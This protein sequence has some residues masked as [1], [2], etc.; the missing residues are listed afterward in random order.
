[1]VTLSTLMY[2]I[3][4][5]RI[6]SVTMWYHFAFMAVSVAM[7]GMTVGAILVYLAPTFFAPE[8]VRYHLALSSTLFSVF[9]VVSFLIHLRIPFAPDLPTLRIARL[10]PFALTY[11]VV[12]IPFILSGVCVCLALTKF[13]RDVSRMYA[14]DLAGAAIGC[15]A[16]IYTLNI[17]DGPTAV[18]AVAALAGIG[19]VLFALDSG[20]AWLTAIAA[21]SAVVLSSLAVAHTVLVRNGS[22]LLRITY[23][24]GQRESPPL[25]EK[26]N[27]F[28]RITVVGSRDV[29]GPPSGWGLSPAWR[30]RT[31]VRQLCLWIDSAAATPLTAFDGNLDGVRHLKYDVTNV[32]HYVRPNSKVLVI[33]VG[34]GRDILSA[35]AFHQRSVLGVEMNEN[36]IDAVNH[37]FGAFTGHL[38][39]NPRITFVAD[40]ARSYVTR[41][42]E[43]FDIIQVSLID[44]WAATA[45][46]AFVLAEQSLY[47]VEAWDAFLEKLTPAGVLTFSRWYFSS[48]PGEMYR[49]ASLA[50]VSLEKLGVKDPRN[51]IVI[52]CKMPGGPQPDAPMG[53][54][55]IL[56]SKRPFS[57]RDLDTID[58]VSRKMGFEVVLSPR[59]TH[60]R[61]F[62]AIATVKDLDA[63]IAGLPF[64]ITAPTDDS[65]F[66]FHML[67]LRDMFGQ[68]PWREGYAAINV[69]AVAV[70]GWL[71]IVVIVLTFLCIFVPLLLTAKRAALGGALPLMAFFGSIGLGFMLIEISQLQRLVVFL[72]HP[73]YALS[74]VLFSLLVSSSL[75]SYLTGGAEDR[76]LGRSGRAR[77]LLLLVVLVAFGLLTPRLIPVFRGSITGV[78]I[79]VATGILLPLGLFMGMPFP[80]GMKLAAERSRSLTPW[81]WGINGATSVCASVLAVAIALSAGISAAFW[82]GLLCYA[83]ALLAFVGASRGRA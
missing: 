42:E 73:S 78:R 17:T 36:I 76:D 67:R 60:A 22:P 29:A 64:N 7:F 26:W 10:Y 38:D 8:R 70:L 39:R 82:T 49:L 24:K 9:I 52:V 6:F 20:R 68:R 63:Y 79:L 14:A 44:T 80:L 72:G 1:M 74:V 35:L 56:A 4:L 83:A 19:A 59:R 27:A 55:T 47:T 50:R 66:F 30:H 81:L 3:L 33:G 71:L 65:P 21:V 43:R 23:V 46:G 48:K 18:I 51:H 57:H 62:G 61:V 53:V 16:L 41:Q 58:R 45:A 37:R 54:G 2:E 15:V 75:G 28:S 69:K 12:A 31:P 25:Y 34:G 5:T 13:P 32:V 40:E 11:V 77:I